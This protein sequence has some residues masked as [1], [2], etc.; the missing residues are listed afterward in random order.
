MNFKGVSWKHWDVVGVWASALIR[1]RFSLRW[2]LLRFPGFIE[3]GTYANKYQN[4]V[5]S[6]L[7]CLIRVAQNF[8]GPGQ[9]GCL[10]R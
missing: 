4:M 1:L 8:L 6:D 10:R 9:L 7:L 2:L 3:S 5:G